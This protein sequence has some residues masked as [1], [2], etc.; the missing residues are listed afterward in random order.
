MR[1]FDEVHEQPL[2]TDEQVL[3]RVQELL[4][5]GIR[6]QLWLMFLDGADRQLPLL[7]P[8]DIPRRPGQRDATDLARFIHGIIDEIDATSVVAT[9][10]RRGSD[11]IG[12]DD[13][14][15]FRLVRDACEM[16]EVKLRGP[17]LC[18]ANGVRWVAAEDYVMG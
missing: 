2:E 12:D 7:M 16:A 3:E 11:T 10:E 14:E 9:L 18:H 8:T 5:N 6:Q 17:L 13:R 4:R 15:W 1:T